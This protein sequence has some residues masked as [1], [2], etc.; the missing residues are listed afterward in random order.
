LYLISG[1]QTKINKIIIHTF[2]PPLPRFPFAPGG[3]SKP[4]L[5]FGPVNPR[6]PVSP[7]L[8]SN[9]FSPLSPPWALPGESGPFIPLRPTSPFLPSPPYNENQ[10]L[11]YSVLL[12]LL[13]LIQTNTISRYPTA[14]RSAFLLIRHSKY[15]RVVNNTLLQTAFSTILPTGYAL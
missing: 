4:F 12:K 6:F 14:W 9:P 10:K 7:T 13:T 11:N 3:P 2:H 5:P 8:P 1:I 15:S